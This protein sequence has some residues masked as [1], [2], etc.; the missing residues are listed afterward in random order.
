MATVRNVTKSLAV[1]EDLATGVGSVLQK[2]GAGQRIDVPYVVDSI[3]E[4][5]E[6]DTSRWHLARVYF[7]E[8]NYKDYVF[9][10]GSWVER[11]TFSSQV[12]NDD[13]STVQEFVNSTNKEGVAVWNAG[14]TYPTNALVKGSDG[15]LYTALNEQQGNDPTSDSGNYWK[16]YIGKYLTDNTNY[17]LAESFGS[18]RDTA[19]MQAAVDYAN[20]NG[21]KYIQVN[22]DWSIG[23]INNKGNVIFVGKGS[24]SG[25]YRK[26]VSD[27]EFDSVLSF[28]DLI[29]S[30]HMKRFLAEENPVVVIVGDS[31]GTDEGGNVP[32]SSTLFA[33]L[34]NKL[35]DAYPNKNITFYNRS[36][37]GET[38]FTAVGLPFS[39][40]QWYTDQGLG[41]PIYVGNLNPD[42]VIFNF[43]MNDSFGLQSSVLDNY[44]NLFD[45]GAF[46]AGRP[47]VIYCTNLTP[48]L[49]SPIGDFGTQQGQS[50]RDYVAGYTRNYAKAVGAGLLD[51]H[52]MCTIVKDG[53]DPTDTELKSQG[54]ITP[55]SGAVA[56]N[57]QCTDFKWELDLTLAIGTNMAVK[58]GAAET[59]DPA[60]R[61][62][63]VVISNSGGNLAADFADTLT[64]VY[65]GIVTSV[66]VPAG[67][68]TLTVEKKQNSVTILVNGNEAVYFAKV[69]CAGRDFTPRA[70]DANYQ[71]GSITAANFWGGSYKRYRQS[72][73]NNDMW[74]E[75][76][77]TTETREPWGGNGVNHPST[78][79]ASSVYQPVIDSSNFGYS[80]PSVLSQQIEPVTFV[81]GWVQ[82][83]G[84]SECTVSRTG[85]MCV[86]QFTMQPPAPATQGV[87]FTVPAQFRPPASTT[88][89]C[90]V[91]NPG[92]TDRIGQIKPNG[93][94]E[95]F[96]SVTGYCFGQ[97]TYPVE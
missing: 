60:G 11:K 15:Q 92:G 10:Q 90:V 49:D 85:S 48:S 36:I 23:E 93:D 33:R 27:S 94:F 81:N 91:T 61:G 72:L 54:A 68:F 2:R 51:F 62:A 26:Y 44:Q 88:A 86:I 8:S 69:R 9:L 40:P 20:S 83:S 24:I 95:V 5:Q 14:V 82:E 58:L 37:G 13:G 47:D 45:G 59:I 43:G 97:L 38:Y 79:G 12:I 39:F 64:N 4:M 31:L 55:V 71:S 53:Y 75:P 63:F 25:V 77:S 50:G 6:L 73:T 41:W 28:N 67:S 78:I 65:K 52:R 96:G 34:K 22:D 87:A 21:Y 76:S 32:Q 57:V 17:V 7:T 46:P 1:M 66:A 70:G 19:T 18:N 29:P 84:F 80:L 30:V 56:G 42:L 74:G 3:A 35:T 16:N 89:N